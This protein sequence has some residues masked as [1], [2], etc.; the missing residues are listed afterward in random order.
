[1]WKKK[2]DNWRGTGWR[3]H[4][5][6]L[7]MFISALL[8]SSLNK[9]SPYALPLAVVLSLIINS[10]PTFTVFASLRKVFFT[11]GKNPVKN[12]FCL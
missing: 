3:V 7:G 8:L 9:L 10:V 6:S 12:S 2:L 11:G 1:M 5:L 4:T